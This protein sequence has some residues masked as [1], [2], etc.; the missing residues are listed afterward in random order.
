V[1][2]DSGFDRKNFITKLVRGG[3]MKRN[4]YDDFALWLQTYKLQ[5]AGPIRNNPATR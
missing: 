5:T 2:R 3:A 1:A 4:S